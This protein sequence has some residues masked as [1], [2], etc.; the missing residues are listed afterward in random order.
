METALLY[1]PVGQ[2]ETLLKILLKKTSI[3][4]SIIVLYKEFR[5]S[6]LQHSE[7]ITGILSEY[8]NS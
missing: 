4:K 2:M 8:N 5:P 7:N 1:M 6:A 3:N